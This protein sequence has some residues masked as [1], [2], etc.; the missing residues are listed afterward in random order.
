MRERL[1]LVEQR[2]ANA[3]RR[4]SLRSRFEPPAKHPVEIQAD[5]ALEQL[6]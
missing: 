4:R 2:A 1:R 6:G 3:F 5:M